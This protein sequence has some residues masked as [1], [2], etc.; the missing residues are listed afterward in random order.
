MASLPRTLGGMWGDIN[1]RYFSSTL[2]GAREVS[3]KWVANNAEGAHLDSRHERASTNL[4]EGKWFVEL[5]EGLKEFQEMAYLAL[6]HEAAHMKIG[7]E[8]DH[9]SAEW[10]KE[11]RRLTGLGL[12][13]RV[14]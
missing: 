3:L 4:V 2:P 7:L 9:R 11:I 6:V 8:H 5:N 14:F 12:L 10:K 1:R 13:G